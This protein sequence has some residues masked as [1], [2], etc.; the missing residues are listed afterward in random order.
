MQRVLLGAEVA[1]QS[2]GS[3]AV[4]TAGARHHHTHM[5]VAEA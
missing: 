5:L 1:L 4:L 3:G 2:P